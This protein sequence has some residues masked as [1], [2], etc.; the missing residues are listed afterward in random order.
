MLGGAAAA[1]PLAASAQQTTS[2][3]RRI[4]VLMA[5]AES[6]PE[7]RA[8]VAAFTRELDTL[9]WSVNRNLQ[10]DYRFAAGDAQR[11][12]AFAKELAELPVDLIVTRS[13]PV[14]TAVVKQTRSIPIVFTQVIDAERQGFVATHS[15]PGANVTGITNFEGPIASKWLELL[16]EIAPTVEKVAVIFNPAAAPFADF[17]LRSVETTASSFA[18]KPI[19]APIHNALEIE[20]VIDSFAIERGGGLIVVPDA[21]TTLHRDTIIATAA[22]HRLPAIYALPI[23]ALDGGL[24]SYGPDPINA[25]RQ[26]A[27]YV[28]RILKGAKP[29]DL[30]VQAPTKFLLVVNLKT[31]K[32]LGLDVPWFL[33]QRA[34]EVI[35]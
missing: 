6:D 19:A 12:Q 5:L 28:D 9:G 21:F 17:F 35:E 27:S 3:P 20:R 16:K 22:K 11:L 34:D 24:I 2:R 10:I 30:P 4:A 31:A 26:A 18:V 14:L 7:A 29:A 13:T 8:A 32:A 1:W 25:F 15:R 33:Q 23:F